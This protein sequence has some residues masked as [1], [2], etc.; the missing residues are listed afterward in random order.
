M[1]KVSLY[2]G[3]FLVLFLMI[4][5]YTA[6]AGDLRA[7]DGTWLKMTIKA[8]KGVEFTGYDSTA[9]PKKMNAGAEKY[10]VCMNVDQAVEDNALALLTFFDKDGVAS[11]YGFITWDAGTDLDFVGFMS[12]NTATDVSYIAADYSPYD[13]STYGPISVKAKDVEH[14]KFQSMGGTSGRLQASTVT[15]TT[16]DYAVFG[17]NINGTIAKGSNIPSASCGWETLPQPL[18]PMPI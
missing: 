10:Y 16:G 15:E 5:V 13:T 4:G 2:T 14:A 3:A 9:A 1:K 12:T 17:V 8:Q 18:P 7:W 6:Q 11:G